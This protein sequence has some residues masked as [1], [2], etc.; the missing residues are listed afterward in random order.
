MV[1]IFG[2]AADKYQAKRDALNKDSKAKDR[3]VYQAKLAGETGMATAF[4]AIRAKGA[5]PLMYTTVPGPSPGAARTFVTDPNKV[6]KVV[7][8]AWAKVYEGKASIK[9]NI[10]ANFIS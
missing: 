9:D 6:D 10:A 7:R 5:P 1:I 4:R 2:R 8:D 3:E